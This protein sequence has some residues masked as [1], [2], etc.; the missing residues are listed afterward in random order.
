M[1]LKNRVQGRS[2][3][4]DVWDATPYKF[5]KRLDNG[6]AYVVVP[7][8]A[9]TAEEEFKKTIHRND[10]LHEKHRVR[11]IA[12]DDD[13]IG[14]GSRNASGNAVGDD[15]PLDTKASSSDEDDVVEA[16]IPCRQSGC[17]VAVPHE[18]PSEVDVQVTYGNGNHTQNQVEVPEEDAPDPDHVDEPPVGDCA[19]NEGAAPTV[20]ADPE[21]STDGADPE[22]STDSDDPELSTGAVDPEKAEAQR[23]STS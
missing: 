20:Q 13:N 14:H 16:V 11:D 10:I 2:K 23:A 19:V 1:F 6:N 21:L 5:V 7:L 4:Q 18:S 12:F 17:P 9:T 15:V 3:I 22:F 8:V